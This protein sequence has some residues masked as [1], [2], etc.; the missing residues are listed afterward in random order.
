MQDVRGRLVASGEGAGIAA[1]V[2]LPLDGTK[3]DRQEDDDRNRC[4]ASQRYRADSNVDGHAVTAV[5][6]DP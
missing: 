2:E 6:E 4:I 5:D 1:S 3:R